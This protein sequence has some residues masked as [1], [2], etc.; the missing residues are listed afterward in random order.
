[1]LAVH[2]G[3]GNIGRG[4]IGEVLHKNGYDIYFVD[5]AQPLIDQLNEQKSYYIRLAQEKEET[6][7]IK[8]VYGL[9]SQTQ[10][11]EV[12]DTLAKADLITVS[13]G[14]NILPLIAPILAK[15]L[16]KR[17]EAGAGAV[18][19]IAC[20][21]AIGA[22]TTLKGHVLDEMKDN[23]AKE[24][25]L[26]NVGFPD[27][28]VD[29]IVPNQTRDGLNVLVEPFFEWVV[30]A[31]GMKTGER[32]QGVNYVEEL[33]PY[34]ERKLYTVNTGHACLAYV[35][36]AK[37]IPSIAE[38][39]ADQSIRKELEEVLKE[40]SRLLEEKY[41]FDGAELKE[42]REKIIS[43]FENV[44]LSD[45]VERVGRNPLRKLSASD[46]LIGP[47]VQLY[48]RGIQSPHLVKVAAAAFQFDVPSDEE[49]VKIQSMLKEK[50]LE[51]TITK[52]TSLSAD[53]PLVT[54]IK[55]QLE[56]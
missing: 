55:E 24:A 50:G 22:S 3:A 33:N 2:F 8:N 53:H 56:A 49:S 14:V 42:Y 52:V 4:F 27:A 16:L 18:D 48:D 29:R 20:E 40:T 26:A 35:G 39:V 46:R 6:V 41:Q 34:I 47:L 45:P 11:D 30:A 28:A 9:N 10:A 17:V 13:A 12:I 7:L 38:A 44:H 5:V 43:R 32:L 37:G 31:K 36:F 54:Q 23:K 25:I 1:M 15:G 51:E 19:V 21:N